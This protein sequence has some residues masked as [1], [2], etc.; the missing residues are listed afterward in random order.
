MPATSFV[1]CASTLNMAHWAKFD[2][3]GMLRKRLVPVKLFVAIQQAVLKAHTGGD[4]TFGRLD[5]IKSAELR[6]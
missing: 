5:T 6:G 2:E 4:R 3:L 1:K